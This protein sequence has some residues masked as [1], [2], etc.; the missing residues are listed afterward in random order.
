MR[1]YFCAK[2][3]L[4]NVFLVVLLFFIIH[5]LI[6][7]LFVLTNVQGKTKYLGEGIVRKEI[8]RM[9]LFRL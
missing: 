8:S 5:V 9:F 3:L 6:I 2:D 4:R 1:L 7:T